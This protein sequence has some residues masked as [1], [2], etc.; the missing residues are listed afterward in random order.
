MKSPE[1]VRRIP[2]QESYLDLSPLSVT[3]PGPLVGEETFTST[4]TTAGA[5]LDPRRSRGRYPGRGGRRHRRTPVEGGRHGVLS[6]VETVDG[7]GPGR[8]G[9]ECARLDCRWDGPGRGVG[10]PPAAGTSHSAR[11]GE[12]SSGQSGRPRSTKDPQT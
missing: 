3:R 10:P 2:K 6:R 9:A 1:R 7:L 4:E 12:G 11:V 8:S 5:L